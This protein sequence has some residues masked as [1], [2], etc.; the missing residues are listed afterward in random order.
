MFALAFAACGSDASPERAV[1]PAST[2]TIATGRGLLVRV[3][4]T[5]AGQVDRVVFEFEDELPGYRAEYVQRPVL[6]DGS[7]EVVEIEGESVLLVRFEPASGFDQ[8]GEGRVVFKGP[9]RL[10][11]AT[12]TV[13]DVVRVGDFEAVLQWAIGI[14]GGELPYRLVPDAAAHT[15]TVEV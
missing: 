3:R 4:A 2:T 10:D 7:G 13:V 14:D 12:E 1:A 6:E 8:S 9:E 5:K 15:V 11:L